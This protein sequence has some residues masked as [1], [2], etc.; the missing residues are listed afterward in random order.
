MVA[1]SLRPVELWGTGVLVWNHGAIRA[2]TKMERE[3][4][5]PGIENQEKLQAEYFLLSQNEV[6]FISHIIGLKKP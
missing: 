3:K 1:L 4:G 2:F 5:G 6:H